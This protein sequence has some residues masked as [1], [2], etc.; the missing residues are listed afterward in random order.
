MTVPSLLVF[1]FNLNLLSPKYFL[2]VFLALIVDFA[3]L[4]GAAV[5]V[6]VGTSVGFTVGVA[7]G[8]SV[9]VVDGITVGAMLG[10]AVGLILGLSVGTCVGVTVGLAIGISVGFTLGVTFA[11]F[12]VA[13]PDLIFAAF[14]NNTAA[15][16]VGTDYTY[17]WWAVTRF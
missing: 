14:F 13:E 12:G 10:L 3:F 9:G 1:A 17:R 7:F 15:G 5:G 6:T 8:S 4:A 11:L 16:G 2:Y